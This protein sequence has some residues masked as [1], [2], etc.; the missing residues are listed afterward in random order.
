MSA[1]DAAP[2]PAR[3]GP[4]GT[5]LDHIYCC[6][7]DVAL[8][9]TDISDAPEIDPNSEINCVVCADLEFQPCALCC[10]RPTP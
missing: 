5:D 1:L 3:T 10:P 4:G 6:D 7:P 8:C 2:T 9:G